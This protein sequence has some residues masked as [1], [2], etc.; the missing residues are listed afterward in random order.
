MAWH[1]SNDY[2]DLSYLIGRELVYGSGL[3][4]FSKPDGSV[5]IIEEYKNT[6]LL[7]MEW[8]YSIWYGF[9]MPSRTV[10]YLIPKASLAVGDVKLFVKDNNM[11]LTADN[12]ASLKYEMDYNVK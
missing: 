3:S 4:L 12:I 7:E 6:V 11:P 10:R 2:H 9:N 5:K 1:R 8:K